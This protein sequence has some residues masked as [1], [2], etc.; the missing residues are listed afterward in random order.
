MKD[1]VADV[2]LLLA[3]IAVV[4]GL[5]ALG[6]LA[7]VT[8]DDRAAWLGEVTT[9]NRA[10]K[11]DMVP[12]PDQAAANAGSHLGDSWVWYCATGMK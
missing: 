6:A 9:V 2:M 7:R 8:R 11:P 5:F 12:C 10:P 1:H 4:V 3:I